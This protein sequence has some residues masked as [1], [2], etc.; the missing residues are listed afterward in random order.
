MSQ[1]SIAGKRAKKEKF[2]D[3]QKRDL[4]ILKQRVHSL[5]ESDDDDEIEDDTSNANLFRDYAG[6][7]VDVARV[8]QFLQSGGV[9][10][11]ICKLN[12]QS[13]ITQVVWLKNS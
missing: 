10:C 5:E 1:K 4:E 8:T 7:E 6:S 12:F 3:I 2:E 13:N 11:L 9:D